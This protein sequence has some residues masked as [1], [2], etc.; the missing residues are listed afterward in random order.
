[1]PSDIAKAQAVAAPFVDMGVATPVAN[2]LATLVR[3]QADANVFVR[4]VIGA[5]PEPNQERVLTNIS[6]NVYSAAHTG[7][8]VG[9]TTVGAWVTLWF[10]F[11]RAE[12][13]VITTAPTWR[14]VKDLLWTEVHK[15]A[16]K[17]ELDKI[18]WTFPYELLS[19]RLVIREEWFATGESTDDPFKLEGYHAPH[20]M[21][22][23]DEAKGVPDSHFDA[24]D[25]GMTTKEA[26][27]VLLSTPGGTVG[28]LY[29]VCTGQENRKL[30]EAGLEDRWHIVHVN[31]EDSDNVSKKYIAGR[32]AV[33]GETSATYRMR[34]KGEFVDVTDDTLV[35]PAEVE[36]CQDL[37]DDIDDFLR[38]HQT[39]R[40]RKVIAID[41][42]RFGADRSIV[43]MRTGNHVHDIL[44]KYDS[45]DSV[46]L[47]DAI[48][49]DVIK[50]FKPDEVWVDVT[51]VGSGV[52]DQLIRK[53]GM[54]MKVLEFVA[55]SKP[56]DEELYLNRRAEVYHGILRER[57]KEG[58]I[59]LPKDEL[60]E[61]QLSSMRFE[62]RPRGQFTVIKMRSKE[63]MRK[64]GEDS[65]DE[66]DA[67]SMLFASEGD[68]PNA[69]GQG[70]WV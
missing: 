47:A 41:V 55:G 8:G 37:L 57:I 13:K 32:K 24:M 35:T 61:T 29:R 7:H 11:T 65:P 28:K 70:V 49:E 52:F 16:R 3:A 63:E 21:Y 27:Q 6:N 18:G 56:Y 45:M 34:V 15:W 48:Y 1:M 14:Q 36:H 30:E 42:A 10:E 64:A 54:S 50:P 20:I 5:V 26:K 19:T 17:M 39:K 67:I 40:P 69:P 58:V 12:A 62:F 66:A 2:Q 38:D 9:K 68:D 44:H 51:G 43:A 4:E 23:I 59:T 60:L 46:E 53:P 31:A 33:W 25:G 22:I